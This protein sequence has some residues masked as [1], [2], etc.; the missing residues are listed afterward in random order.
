[1]DAKLL[2]LLLI[3]LA[4]TACAQ[5]QSN[6]GEGFETEEFSVTDSEL[7]PNQET[8]I[9]VTI[10]NFNTGESRLDSDNIELFNTGQLEIKNKNCNPDEIGSAREELKPKIRC[11]WNVKAPG[12]DF[13][14]GFESK[15]IPFN[16]M[17]EFDSSLE[18]EKPLTVDVSSDPSKSTETVSKQFSNNDIEISMETVNPVP[19]DGKRNLNIG[20]E[21]IGSGNLKSGFNFTYTPEELFENCPEESEPID[22][23]TSFDCDLNANSEGSRKAFFSTS[24]KY[25]RVLSKSIEVVGN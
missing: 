25:E 23:G 10:T 1:M 15:P 9:E 22:S 24:Y 17:Y 20:V 6:T 13:I 8:I 11:T 4:T 12:E 3:V 16:L 14:R 21:E 18:S 7:R 5:D 19:V 2:T